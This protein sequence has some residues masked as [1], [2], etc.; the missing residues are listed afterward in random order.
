MEGFLS[1]NSTACEQFV[2]VTFRDVNEL[3]QNVKVER[4]IDPSCSNEKIPDM[5]VDGVLDGKEHN[6]NRQL[7]PSSGMVGGYHVTE[8]VAGSPILKSLN[9]IIEPEGDEVRHFRA[10][11]C[12][13]ILA[14]RTESQ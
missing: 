7:C 2:K 14:I 3:T 8:Q 9:R 13:Y 1:N 4:G 12:D 11:F 10:L 6:R 5:A